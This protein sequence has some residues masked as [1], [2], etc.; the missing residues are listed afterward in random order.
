MVAHWRFL[1]FLLATAARQVSA[2]SPLR[3]P[4]CRARQRS[5]APE[6]PSSSP[7]RMHGGVACRLRA[8]MPSVEHHSGIRQQAST[9]GDERAGLDGACH[10]QLHP[11]DRG[12]YSSPRVRARSLGRAS[13]SRSRKRGSASSSR[14]DMRVPLSVPSTTLLATP[15]T[16]RRPFLRPPVDR[17]RPHAA[18]GC[19]ILAPQCRRAGLQRVANR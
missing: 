13:A 2:P 11:N 1:N 14:R 7:S 9:P 17:Q 12:R 16:T 18:S 6:W 4:S 10:Q 5:P 8:L 15:A 19:H 3:R